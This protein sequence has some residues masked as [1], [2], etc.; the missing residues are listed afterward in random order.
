[1]IFKG[2]GVAIVTPFKKDMSINYDKMSELVDYH[3]KNNT[4]AII[5]SGTTGESST[6]SNDEKKQVIK[7]VVE[8]VNKKIPVI[9][10]TG[11]NNT[12]I[13]CEMSKYAKEVGCD[14]ILVVTPYYNKASQ[15][16]LIK[17]Y[18]KIATYASGLPIIL[19]NVPSRTGVDMSVN[20]IVKLS[21]I[22]NIV[23]IKE[24]SPNISK[25]SEIIANCDENFS[26]YSGNDDL[27]LPILSLGGAGVISVIAN[28][29]PEYMHN[30]CKHYFDG[31]ICSAQKIHYKLLNLMNA[32]FDDVNPICI[33]QA[34][35][36]LK[37]D[38]GDVRLPLCKTS[39]K[40]IENIRKQLKSIK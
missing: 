7:F 26:V 36:E 28:I 23:G 5:V 24:A 1:M 8:K 31:D 30:I 6:L 21:K 25:V 11:S 32:L 13:A 20:T 34:L 37:F 40:N 29:Y 17:H 27:T 18:T 39:K 10:G 3:I 15:M 14:G 16:G 35:N 12:K 2:S 22:D 9:A 38:V 4:D 33:K 19:Y